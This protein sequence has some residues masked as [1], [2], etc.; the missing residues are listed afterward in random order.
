MVT[1]RSREF[2]AS[3]IACGRSLSH[4]AMHTTEAII[5]RSQIQQ[6]IANCKWKGENMNS[7]RRMSGNPKG[8][9]VLVMFAVLLTM[10]T[11]SA[12]TQQGANH[13]SNQLRRIE[14]GPTTDTTSSARPPQ[15]ATSRISTNGSAVK[16]KVVRIGVLPGKTN[17][18]LTNDVNVINNLGH[19]VGY[20]Y[21]APEAYQ[22][23]QPFLWKDGHLS[24]LPLPK[25]ASAAFA[26][27]INDQD[28][29]IAETNELD[30]NGVRVRRAFIV[31]HGKVVVLPVLNADSN[32]QPFAINNWGSAVGRNH[33][34]V[35]GSETPVVWS[36]GKI[37]ALP[38]LPGED[39]GF[40]F[41][42][43]DLGVIAGYQ[44]PADDSSEVACLWY[45]NGGGY[46]VVAL[47]TLGGNYGE[48]YDINNWGQ[49]AGFST[50]TDD[51]NGFGT[52]WDWRGPHALPML[53]GD[54]DGIANAIND[55]GQI[56]GITG[57]VDQ[58]GNDYQRVV[59]W[60]NG[61]VIDLQTV[62][63]PDTLP[64][65]DI[66]NANRLGQIAIDAGFFPDGS[67]F[68][69]YVLIPKDN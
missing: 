10:T 58:Y 67:S 5:H 33:N 55:Q 34:R 37:H 49:T 18:S 35:D 3:A 44:F 16:Y 59:L 12:N 15:R 27:G 21:V 28:Q 60:Q 9:V 26:T 23:A 63:P 29:V 65:F 20:S 4:G 40:A 45:W 32:T 53:P 47:K 38:L 17:T 7:G 62:V 41:G 48:A 64:F 51:A 13:R 24:A 66:G 56:T 8:S 31:D 22:T 57:G 14:G 43:N 69:G 11:V 52:L 36:S 68:V 50:N 6:R 1:K 39:G 54:T 2:P 25:G 46:T 61:T 19:V 30:S 42:I